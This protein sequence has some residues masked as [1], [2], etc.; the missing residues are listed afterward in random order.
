VFGR[1]DAA[2][3]PQAD[4]PAAGDRIAEIRQALARWQ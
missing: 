2:W 3:R 1:L 4:L